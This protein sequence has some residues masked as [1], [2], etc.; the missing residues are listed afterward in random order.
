M[1]AEFIDAL[2]GRY[3]EMEREIATARRIVMDREVRIDAL[4]RKLPA[5][6]MLAL[7][8]CRASD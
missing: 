6:D 3:I 4:L 8:G 5:E 7:L 1:S 2:L